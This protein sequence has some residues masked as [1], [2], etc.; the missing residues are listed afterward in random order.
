MSHPT[1]T[2]DTTGTTL[3]PPGVAPS[4]AGRHTASTLIRGA[5]AWRTR[6]EGWLLAIGADVL[7]L[8]ARG[9]FAAVL[10]P[11]FWASAWTKLGEGWQGLWAPS[12][13]AYVQIFPQAMEAAG[14]DVGQLAA[15]HT[16]VVIAGTWAELLLP[17]LL[18]V[19]LWTRPA[20]LGMLAFVAVQTATDVW[21][22]G[23]DAATIGAWWDADNG[24]V[25][26]DQRALWSLLFAALLFQGGGALSL[27]GLLRPTISAPRA[28]PHHHPKEG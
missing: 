25:I 6:S 13:G 22:H 14:Y 12:V 8:L 28:Q 18:L 9:V 11:Y 27:D 21:G 3:S 24:S 1:T 23:V 7:P 16:A 15:W 26:A 19:G 10:L 17:A 5:A 2:R 4:P 20:A